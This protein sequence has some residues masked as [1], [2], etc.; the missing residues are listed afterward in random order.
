MAE[1]AR[2]EDWPRTVAEFEAWH[3]RQPE[4][5]EFID[6]QPRLMA[7]ASMKHSIIKARVFAAL[8]GAL[9]GTP[10]TALVDG[11]QIL[12]DEISA[13]PD[14]VVTCS[15]L[16]LSTPVIAEPVI[17]V[18]V[19]SPSSEADDAGRKWFSYRKIPSLK[20]YLVLSQDE[21]VVQLHSRAGELWRER[22]ISAGAI[23][24]DDPS[25]RIEV[26]AIYAGADIA[27]SPPRETA[28]RDTR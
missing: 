23:E 10:C 11:P 27:D 19:M 14:V 15:V 4:R 16:D 22:F 24:L 28:S 3:S 1:A 5:W 13:I 26:E 2:R 8:H 12:T 21:R 17:V 7:P 25:V 20:H 9:A 6:G 18:E